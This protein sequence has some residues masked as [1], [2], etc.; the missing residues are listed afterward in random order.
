MKTII[1]LSGIGGLAPRYHSERTDNT[2][3]PELRIIGADNQYADG[4]VNP[5]AKLGYISP[6]SNTVT[7]V[8]SNPSAIIGSTVIDTVNSKGYFWERGTKLHELDSYTDTTLDVNRIVTGATG[9][10][11][12]IYTVNGVRKLFYAYRHASGGD[13]GIWDFSSIYD[14]TWLSATCASGFNTGTTN[15]TKMIVADNGYMYVLDGSTLHK[16]DGTTAGGA[17]GTVTANVITFP[18]N[19]QLID[20]LD[21]RGNLWIALMRS[22][23]DLYSANTDTS[24]FEE[25]AG[26]Y[27]WNRI[28]TATDMTDFITIEGVREIRNIF[29]FRGIPSCFTV[30]S[31]RYTQLR[32]FNG[33]EFRVVQELGPEAYPRFPDSVHDTGDMMFWL[34]NDGIIYAYGKIIPYG[35]D[36]LYKIG[37]MTGHITAGTTFSS[38]GAIMGAGT[39]Q[40]MFYL[41]IKDSTNALIKQWYPHY[42]TS[43]KYPLAG[44][45]YSMVKTL[46]KLSTVSSITLYYPPVTT[47]ATEVLDVDIYFNQSTTSWG[48]TTLTRADG[49]RT[50]RYIP[51]GESGV[52]FVQLGL[53]WKTGNALSYAITPM[54]A[55][56]EYEPKTKKK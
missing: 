26:V 44:G 48:T 15:N 2:T 29:A 10:D 22:T 34:G 4:T 55:E 28:S 54:Y 13:I 47:G 46:P 45:F 52:N 49:A 37:D 12:E 7:A 14:D 33:N 19:F 56:I 5:I 3:H 36:A 50:Y 11:L 6:A 27:V 24:L 53:R 35:E 32:I 25:L 1:D 8:T 31:A 20:G 23:R 17:N 43:S 39:T 51:I 38:G 41:C 9:T 21:L 40:E 18:A 42:A 16:I 30:S